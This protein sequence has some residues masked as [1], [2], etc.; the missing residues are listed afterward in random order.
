VEAIMVASTTFRAREAKTPN[1][2]RAKTMRHNPVYVE[3]LFWS[4]LR[5]RKLGGWK[6]RRQV[7]IG[8]YIADYVCAQRKVIVELDGGVHKLT[9]ERDRKRD[10]YLRNSGYVVLRFENA[11][12]LCDLP[13]V[14]ARIL[15]AIETAPSPWPSP[16]EG[17]RVF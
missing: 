15:Q 2:S 6:F 10:L 3:R 7:L 1:R 13:D 16:P 11:E 14:L 4:Y 17:E 9:R 5:D 8:S 12:V